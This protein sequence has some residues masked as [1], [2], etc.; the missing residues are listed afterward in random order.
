M[1]LAHEGWWKQ[2]HIIFWHWDRE[3]PMKAHKYNVGEIIIKS[4]ESLYGYI[5]TFSHLSVNSC[6][7]QIKWNSQAR[8]HG[9]IKL[10]NMQSWMYPKC[11]NIG[12][13][14]W[15]WPGNY[16]KTKSSDPWLWLIWYIAIE[17]Q[18]IIVVNKLIFFCKQIVSF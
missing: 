12:F 1:E 10:E 4:W 5:G 7:A 14:M 3:L 2:H 6:D 11:P 8:Q 15:R 9:P 18:I 13:R 16:M 17:L